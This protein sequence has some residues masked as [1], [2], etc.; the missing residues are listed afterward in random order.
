MA[1]LVFACA[2]FPS[3][4]EWGR[5]AAVQGLF[6]RARLWVLERQLLAL[7]LAV[8]GAST[9]FSCLEAW[10]I[11]LDQDCSGSAALAGGFFNH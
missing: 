5:P 3:S 1:A 7:E 8:S 10:W 4:G 11:F 6:R 2:G 9:R